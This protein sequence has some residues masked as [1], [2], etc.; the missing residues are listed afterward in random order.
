MSA[1]T[2]RFPSG[3]TFPPASAGVGSWA[4]SYASL[5]AFGMGLSASQIVFHGT[6][7][8]KGTTDVFN[9]KSV[10]ATITVASTPRGGTI[11][12]NTS[13]TAS[14]FNGLSCVVSN[15][16]GVVGLIKNERW[17]ALGRM[18]FSAGSAQSNHE[19]GVTVGVGGIGLVTGNNSGVG[20]IIINGVA[21]LQINGGGLLTTVATTWTVDTTLYHDILVTFDLTTVR[22]FVDGVQ[23]ASTTTLTNMPN[24]AAGSHA[25]CCV[26]NGT[27]TVNYTLS[28]DALGVFVQPP[29]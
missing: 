25:T 23:V 18:K 29:T 11:L 1:D 28:A 7:I 15:G 16:N 8:D 14:Q 3:N 22:L 17:A 24:A 27:D 4:A 13:T 12:L 9:S 2:G 21:F 19:F 26:I 10:S 6:E 5:A 20:I